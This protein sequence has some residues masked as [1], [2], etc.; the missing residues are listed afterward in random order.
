MAGVTTTVSR[1]VTAHS[2]PLP[3][4][5]TLEG[6]E[7]VLPGAAERILRMAE[8]QQDGRLDLEAR[9]LDADIDHRDEMA[10]IQRRVHTGAFISDYLG[11]LFGFLVALLSLGFAAY[12]GIWRDNWVVAGLFLSLPVVGMIQAVRGMNS[13]PKEDKKQP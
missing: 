11:Q 12:A 10:R 5:E 3:A 4:P 8:K 7:E 6:Y 1:Q 9:Q 13:K 2:G